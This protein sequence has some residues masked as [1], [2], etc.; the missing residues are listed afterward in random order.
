MSEEAQHV[1]EAPRRLW[2]IL[3]CATVALVLGGVAA[4]ITGGMYIQRK[5]KEAINQARV[6]RMEA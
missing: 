2:R 5:R 6:W 3:A 1:K 4:I